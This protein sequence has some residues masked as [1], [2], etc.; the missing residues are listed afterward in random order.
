MITRIFQCDIAGVCGYYKLYLDGREIVHVTSYSKNNTHLISPGYD[1]T[2]NMTQRHVEYLEAH[3]KRR[4]KWHE[5][6]NREYVPLT[7]S[8]QLAEES[9][10]WA[11]QLLDDC[12]L[13]DIAHEPNVKEGENLGK[14]KGLVDEDGQLYSPESELLDYIC[15]L[16]HS[17]GILLIS[18][19]TFLFD[20]IM[21]FLLYSDC[22][23]L[24]RRRDWIVIPR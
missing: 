14:N 23:E 20:S 24:G 12:D 16:F 4:K 3:N 21:S 1:A 13:D 18:T 5:M 19:R 9:R 6:Y 22:K 8:P 7:W 11:E 15:I 17:I 10:L 2:S